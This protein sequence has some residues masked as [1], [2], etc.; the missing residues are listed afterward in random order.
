MIARVM[1]D[2]RSLVSILAIR[3]RS[4]LTR[5]RGNDAS[6]TDARN[7]HSLISVARLDC[8]AT[9]KKAESAGTTAA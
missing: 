9:G 5:D 8:S 6:D 4:S 1:T 3:L 2:A 7:T